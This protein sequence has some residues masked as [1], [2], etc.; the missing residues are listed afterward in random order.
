LL[1]G[2]GLDD[3]R[4]KVALLGQLREGRIGWEGRRG[5]FEV[6]VENGEFEFLEFVVED[7]AEVRLS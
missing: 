1:A 6:E 7:E 3:W 2:F 4:E 5:A